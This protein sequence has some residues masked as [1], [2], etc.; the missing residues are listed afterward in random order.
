MNDKI[1]GIAA[2]GLAALTLVFSQPCSASVTES[3]AGRAPLVAQAESFPGQSMPGTVPSAIPGSESPKTFPPGVIGQPSQLGKDGPLVA[4]AISFVDVN[5]GR[6]GKMELDIDDGEFHSGSC[7]NL[8]VLARDLDLNKGI[9]KS[10][11]IAITD[12]HLKDFIFDHL[13]MTT[14]GAMTFD[15]GILLNHQMFQFNQPVEAEV[16]AE[17]SQESLNKFLN[18]PSTLDRFSLSAGKNLGFLAQFFGGKAPN[19]GLNVSNANLEL[20]KGDR[21]NLKFQS[22]VGV[23]QMAVPIPVEVQAKLV[24][25]DGWL[26][27]ADTKLLTSGQE[28]SPQLSKFIVDRVN[29]LSNIGARSGDIHFKF[30]KMKVRSGK[31]ITLTGT[32]EVSRLRF[33]A[34]QS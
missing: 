33:G 24:L 30:T 32:A 20:Q 15:T 34:K 18:A 23:G 5:T 8:H 29:K 11:D 26:K 13:T 19:V 6:F 16:T 22:S 21:L 14:Q 1:C 31:G 3:D 10:L 9:L 25:V 7:K 28:I 17:I 27:V 4:P 12:G 2:S